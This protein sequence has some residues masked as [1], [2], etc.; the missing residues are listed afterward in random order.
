MRDDG[1]AA[2]ACEQGAPPQQTTHA[3]SAHG[4]TAHDGRDTD[5]AQVSVSRGTDQE[6]VARMPQGRSSPREA[7]SCVLAETWVG[8]EAITQREIPQGH[9]SPQEAWSCVLAEIWV[10]LEAITQRDVSERENAAP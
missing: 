6:D 5:A 4:R 2:V 3:P 9:Y 7:W 1:E 8:L 10:D